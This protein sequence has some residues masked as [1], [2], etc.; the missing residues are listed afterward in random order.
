MNVMLMFSRGNNALKRRTMRRFYRR[1]L[2]P[3]WKS[4]KWLILFGFGLLAIIFGYWGFLINSMESGNNYSFWDLLILTLRLFLFQT[5]SIYENPCWQLNFA[6]FLAPALTFT[7]LYTLILVSL[8]SYVEGFRLRSSKCHVIICGLGYLGPIFAN[9]LYKNGHKVVVIERD[10]DNPTIEVCRD[11]GIA[12]VIGDA[13]NPDFFGKL[14]PNKAKCIFAVTGDDRLNIEIA[15]NVMRFSDKERAIPLNCYVHVVDPRLQVLLTP[16]QVRSKSDSSVRLEFFNIYQIA[17]YCLFEEICPPFKRPSGTDNIPPD[18]HLLIIG[19]GKM[20]E[21]FLLYTVKQWREAFGRSGK[22]ITITA[23]DLDA[24]AKCKFLTMQ[25]PSLERYCTLIPRQIDVRDPDLLQA[26]YLCDGPGNNGISSTYILIPD[27]SLGLSTAFRF[28]QFFSQNPEKCDIPIVLRTLYEEGFAK[29]FNQFIRTHPLMS[30][31][32]AFPLVNCYCCM[33][34]LMRGITG[35]M[36]RLIHEEYIDQQRREGATIETNP[37]I[38]LWRDLSPLKRESNYCQADHIWEKLQAVH[39]GVEVLTNWDEPLFVFTPEEVEK[40]AIME[41]VRWMKEKTLLGFT[42]GDKN[43]E[44]KKTHT[45]LVEWDKLPNNEKEKDR[46]A[47]RVLP[48]ILAQVDLKI[49][50]IPEKVYSSKISHPRK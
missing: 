34:M 3:P 42:L 21:S 5:A 10:A 45:C 38:V 15:L 9:T 30:K 13:S 24:K 40:L 31:I 8:S 36:A 20:G 17:G 18:I 49:I 41:H 50:R 6:R 39:C 28:H 11:N 27:E 2:L 4:Y 48:K 46:N 29:M 16:H 12:V 19:L 44:L 23:V 7:A 43:D 47:I 35:F 32:K 1:Y 25:Y 33:Y 26:N 14:N 37:S 22:K